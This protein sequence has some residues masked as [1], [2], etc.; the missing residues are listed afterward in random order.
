M[1][2]VEC[3]HGVSIEESPF[4]RLCCALNHGIIKVGKDLQNHLVQPSVHPP[5]LINHVPRCHISM[6]LEHLQGWWLHHLPGQLCITTISEKKFFLISN[7]RAPEKLCSFPAGHIGLGHG[8]KVMDALL[9]SSKA[10]L[11]HV[12][13]CLRATISLQPRTSCLHHKPRRKYLLAGSPSCS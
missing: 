10:S 3:A 5:M 11:L 13:I 2:G 9:N 12:C 7:L 1:W 6:V 8:C 4:L